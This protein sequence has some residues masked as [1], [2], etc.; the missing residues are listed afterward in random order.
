M[1]KFIGI[2]IAIM[3]Y[4]VACAISWGVTALLIMAIC[5]L[6]SLEFTIKMAT[7]VWLV[8]FLIR[9]MLSRSTNS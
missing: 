1:S 6:F 2:M 5:W 9:S 4:L 7:G 3:V 8:M